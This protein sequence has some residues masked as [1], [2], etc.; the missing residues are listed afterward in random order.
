MLFVLNTR[1]PILQYFIYSTSWLATVNYVNYYKQDIM[2][3]LCK[4]KKM[5]GTMLLFYQ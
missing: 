5:T 4:K 2:D 1:T 3:C